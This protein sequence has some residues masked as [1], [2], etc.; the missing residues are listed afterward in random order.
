MGEAPVRVLTCR[1]VFSVL[2]PLNSFLLVPLLCSPYQRVGGLRPRA[3]AMRAHQ[4][5]V[6]AVEALLPGRLQEAPVRIDVRGRS[7][8]VGRAWGSRPKRQ[9]G[10]FQ[11]CRAAGW[12]LGTPASERA[13]R[14]DGLQHVEKKKK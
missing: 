8:Q 3:D 5:P 7:T 14:L 1:L 13:L 10:G 6:S 4:T 9:Q 2:K 12:R 11:G